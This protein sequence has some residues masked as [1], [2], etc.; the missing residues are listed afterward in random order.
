MT[1][2]TFDYYNFRI[3]NVTETIKN[4][5]NFYK[6]HEYRNTS[7]I[8][9]YTNYL[10]NRISSD[11]P[12]STHVPHYD[13]GGNKVEIKK[14]N[15]DE[16]S[17]DIDIMMYKRPWTK[18]NQI[19]KITKIRE[20]INNLKYDKKIKS[21]IIEKNREDLINDIIKGLELKKFGK[22][23]NQIEY[24]HINMKI[25]DISCIYYSKKKCIY[26]IKWK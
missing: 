18:L 12:A 24:D 6:T 5:I 22:N 7:I 3:I 19:H 2:S 25:N 10:I 13:K 20:Y 4:E 17:K 21:T 1:D 23:K 11:K 15:M 26:T 8:S 14:M 9:S 16:Y